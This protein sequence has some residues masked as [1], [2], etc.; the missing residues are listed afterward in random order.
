MVMANKTDGKGGIVLY[1]G[2]MD[3]LVPV[4]SE[5]YTASSHFKYAGKLIA[6]SFLHASFGLTGLSRDITE[7]PVTEDVNSSL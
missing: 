4:H 6:H 3:H 5:E 2:K 7:Y 1:V